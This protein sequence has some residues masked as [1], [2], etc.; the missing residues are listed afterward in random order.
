[1]L[2]S[3]FCIYYVSKKWCTIAAK[4]WLR[5]SKTNT[6]N[7]LSNLCTVRGHSTTTWTEFCH[8]LTPRTVLDSFYTLSVDK[9]RHFLTPSPPHLVHVV[10]ECPLKWKILLRNIESVKHETFPILLYV[11]DLIIYFGCF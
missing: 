6:K 2:I 4:F 9:N 5:N 7:K 11:Y 3:L 10:I 1:M 8:F